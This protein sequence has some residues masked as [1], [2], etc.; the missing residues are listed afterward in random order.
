MVDEKPTS[1]LRA[2]Y[3]AVN[4]EQMNEVSA[5]PQNVVRSFIITNLAGVST[6]GRAYQGRTE[7]TMKL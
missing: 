3:S 4:E 2:S 1:Y 5:L 7:R 6:I